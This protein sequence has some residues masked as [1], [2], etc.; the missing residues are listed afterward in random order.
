MLP[1]V[2][3]KNVL[4]IKMIQLGKIEFITGKIAG[5]EN[6]TTKKGEEKIE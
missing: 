4:T 3:S 2:V 6:F 5:F 1:K